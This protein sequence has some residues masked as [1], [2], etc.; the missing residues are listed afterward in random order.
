[1]LSCELALKEETSN[2]AIMCKKCNSENVVKSGMIAGKQRF[3]CKKCGCNFRIGDNRTD[4]QVLAKKFLCVLLHFMSKTSFRTLGKLLQ[5]DHA[6]AYRWIQEFNGNLSKAQVSNEIK[7]MDFY[8]LQQFIDL[9]KTFWSS[10]SLT[11]VD[12]E[13]WSGCSAT[14]I[15]HFSKGSTTR[16]I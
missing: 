12:G 6:L 11:V 13:L 7:Q 16:D 2:L 4:E 5:T 3:R 1:M 14:V 9:K 15:L 8:E 10:E